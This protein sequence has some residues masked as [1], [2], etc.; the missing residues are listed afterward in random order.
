MTIYILKN[1]YLL[2]C[3]YLYA[4]S[5]M[6]SS[7]LDC[8]FLENINSIFFVMCW[9]W[10]SAFYILSKSIRSLFTWR[11]QVRQCLPY[12]FQE[13]DENNYT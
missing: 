1:M 2:V 4:N 10:P 9:P 6:L 12:S 5:C 13:M 7:S 8:K 11:E 3:T